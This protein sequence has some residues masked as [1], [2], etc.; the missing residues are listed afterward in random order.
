MNNH[1]LL[2][3]LLAA[4]L[5]SGAV[6]AVGPSRQ[7]LTIEQLFEIA[8]TNSAQL[9]PSFTAEEEARREIS[10]A[11]SSRLPDIEANLSLSYIGDGFTTKRSFADYQKAP[12]PHFGNT[13]GINITQPVYAGG[14]ITA[15]IE[16]AE[17]KSTASRYA[18]E[19]QRDNIRF[20]L[21]GFYLDLYKYDNLRTVVENNIV[22]ACRV[23]DEMHAHY[24]QGVA[25][26]ND[27][28]RYE[29]LVSNLELQLVKI[30]NTLTII[31]DNLVTTA[32]LDPATEVRPD[33][34]I[35]ARAL[36]SAGDGWWQ[37]E[38]ENEAPRLK[39]ARSGVEISRTAESLVKSERLP[40]ICLKAGWTVDGPILVEVP[41]INRNLSY[42]YVGVGV[43]Y[44]L[45]SLYK[46]NKSLSKSRAAT[47]TAIDQFEATRQNVSL[48]IRTDY[49]RYLEAYEELKTQQKSV[50]LAL[51]NYHTTSTRYAEGMALITDML[52]AANSKLDA[53]QK[54]V[55]ARINI[56]YCY[57][58]LLFT[59]GK[60]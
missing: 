33:T 25:L 4:A 44:N 51:R 58:K 35:L 20:Q 7:V 29:L 5:S 41:P 26:K 15:G 32:G 13:L 1:R 19:L 36:P 40:K 9:R 45:A 30:D 42:W 22:Q 23:L 2:T 27:I 59:S 52:D 8:E 10:V 50:E 60:I 6:C 53:E 39:L 43:S 21:A 12:I 34:T 17:L 54:L 18:T 49:V 3:G 46:S 37:S 47:Q 48:G 56:I 38:A 57:Y 14:A 16:L 55:D 24:D 11:R 28:T 31:N